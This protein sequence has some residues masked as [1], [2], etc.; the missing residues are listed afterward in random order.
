MELRT[1]DVEQKQDTVAQELC[2][3]LE[4]A[5][6]G[7]ASSRVFEIPEY[8][9]RAIDISLSGGEV[10]GYFKTLVINDWKR[11]EHH[12]GDT[13]ES[14]IGAADLLTGV[15]LILKR[16]GRKVFSD[17]R[18]RLYVLGI[19]PYGGPL[20]EGLEKTPLYQL[21]VSGHTSE[22]WEIT[23]DGRPIRFYTPSMHEGAL[24]LKTWF[25][26][27]TLIPYTHTEQAY[28]HAMREKSQSGN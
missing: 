12:E 22:A 15:A 10:T 17:S 7:G 21:R 19:E 6:R 2:A 24:T 5:G 1:E 25:T 18:D 8:A 11:K 20:V 26:K 16:E 4:K 23:S 28:L 3:L 13:P 14:R 9:R 27:R